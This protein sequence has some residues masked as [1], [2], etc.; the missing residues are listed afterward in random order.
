MQVFNCREK[1]WEYVEPAP[2]TDEEIAELQEQA[3]RDAARAKV[4]ERT[5]PL[6]F[7]EVQEMLVRQQ[8]NNIT[9]DDQTALRMRRYYPTF[10]ELVGQTVSHGTKFRVDDSE[11]AD[12][13]KTI[14]PELTIQAHYPPGVGTESLY[15]RIDETHDGTKYD[16]IP[17]SRGM[18]YE[19]G[20][21]YLD[22]EDGKTYL[23]ERIGEAS[24]GKIVLQYL[25]HEL[26]G[27][28]FT[29]V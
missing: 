15:T 25:P 12:L 13:Y 27:N 24:G 17:A 3:D 7:S 5:R 4:L 9:A 10:A 19:Y 14:Q 29:A 28:Y 26:A 8:I 23:C 1:K 11:D 20:K 18:E 16:P 22:S 2:L 21:Y 6:S